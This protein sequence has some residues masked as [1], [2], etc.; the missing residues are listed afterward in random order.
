V[1]E[2][3]YLFTKL[4]KDPYAAGSFHTPPLLLASIGP[5][6]DSTTCPVWLS[7]FAWTLADVGIAW[8]LSRVA[9]RRK[10]GKLLEDEG[11][12]C[13]NGSRIANL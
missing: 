7:F 6:T 10:R 11:E 4:D 1:Q 3:Y 13:W 2:G 9:D 12:K 8:A 5:L